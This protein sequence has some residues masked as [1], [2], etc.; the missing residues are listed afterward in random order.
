[1][2]MVRKMVCRHCDF[3]FIHDCRFERISV[4]RRTWLRVV[5]TNWW[6]NGWR[7][8]VEPGGLVPMGYGL[9]WQNPCSIRMTFLPIPMNVVMRLFRELCIWLMKGAWLQFPTMQERVDYEVAKR[10]AKVQRDG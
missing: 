9:A 3:E 10:M 4:D 7:V 1:M 2:I 6:D 8:Y 5:V